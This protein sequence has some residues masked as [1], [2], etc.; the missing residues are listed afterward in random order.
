MNLRE[1]VEENKAS[2]QRLQG[3]LQ[4]LKLSEQLHLNNILL[5]LRICS[6]TVLLFFLKK[7]IKQNVW[8]PDESWQSTG[9]LLMLLPIKLILN[10]K[11]DSPVVIVISCFIIYISVPYTL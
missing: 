1:Q 10:W 7:G 8:F 4:V 2:C 11:V 3:I 9:V 6:K 5:G